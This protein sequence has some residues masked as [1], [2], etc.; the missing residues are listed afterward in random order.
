MGLPELDDVTSARLK[1]RPAIEEA[2]EKII[3][4]CGFKKVQVKPPTDAQTSEA[5][6]STGDE[7]SEATTSWNRTLHLYEREPPNE[8]KAKR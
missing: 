8:L 3:E 1:L 7:K 4:Q 2:I 6:E 5:T